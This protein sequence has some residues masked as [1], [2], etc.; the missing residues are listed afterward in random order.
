MERQLNSLI[1][2]RLY[3]KAIRLVRKSFLKVDCERSFGFTY[4]LPKEPCFCI[5]KEE[6]KYIACLHDK[7][8]SDFFGGPAFIQSIRAI[9]KVFKS[10][11]W[12]EKSRPS[13]ID[14]FV[15]IM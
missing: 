12:L 4:F 3:S 1:D 10:S 14:T 11:D 6:S 5:I 9:K 2:T 8:K 7:N 13:K 15:L